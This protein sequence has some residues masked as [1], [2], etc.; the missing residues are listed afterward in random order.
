MSILHAPTYHWTVEE[1]EQLG[2]AGVFH[3]KERVEL[4]NG[5]IIIMSPIGFRHAIAVKRLTK[6]FNRHS[7][8]RYDVTAQLPII[9]DELSEPEPDLALVD[10]AYET[11]RE[12]P[13]PE[14]IFLVIEVSDTTLRYDREDKRPAY[15]RNGVRE[16]WLLNLQA[17]QLEVYREPV[18]DRYRNARVCDA[19]ET[20]FPLAFPDVEVRVG[21]FIP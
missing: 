20:V 2:R 5:E 14:H 17:N 11:T 15:A 19:S 16:F 9:I 7:D 12:H 8:E 4:L 13:K 1:Y 21:D 18:G 10:I 3:G 6:F